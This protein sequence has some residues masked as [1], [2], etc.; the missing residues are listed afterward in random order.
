MNLGFYVESCGGS[1]LNTEIYNFLNKAL[2]DKELE[3]AAV[4]FN[5]INF[6]PVACKFGMFNATELWHFKG[7]L[8]CASIANLRRA[9][10]V[11]NDIK[12]VYLFSVDQKNERTLFDLVHIGKNH[13][14]AVVNEL[15]KREFTRITGVVPVLLNEFSVHNFQEIFDE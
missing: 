14:V 6:N 4:F 15:D 5:S 13:K 8:V 9:F 12:I 2:S 3:D 7:N 1:P 10:Q 11:V